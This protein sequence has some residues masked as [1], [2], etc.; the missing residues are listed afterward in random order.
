MPYDDTIGGGTAGSSG[1]GVA[2]SS[3]KFNF[4]QGYEANKG[5]WVPNGAVAVGMDGTIYV[6]EYYNRRIRT[7]SNDYL[8]TFAGEAPRTT[9]TYCTLS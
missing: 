8:G 9:F 1:D 4:Q 6:S 5:Y 2:A 7:I 3:A